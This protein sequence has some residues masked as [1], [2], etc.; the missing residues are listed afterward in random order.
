MD[1]YISTVVMNGLLFSNRKSTET[2]RRPPLE[3]RRP[4]KRVIVGDFKIP[5]FNFFFGLETSDFLKKLGVVLP[6]ST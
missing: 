2:V 4:P 6:F 3:H 1:A 5:R